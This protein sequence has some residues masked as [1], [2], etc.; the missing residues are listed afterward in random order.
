MRIEI[1]VHELQKLVK[2]AGMGAASRSTKPTLMG[3]KLDAHDDMLTASGTDLDVGVSRTIACQVRRAGAC[4]IPWSKVSQ[5]LGEID[6]FVELSADESGC[7]VKQMGTRNK[8]DFPTTDAA[9]FPDVPSDHAGGSFT[10]R[11]ESLTRALD[12]SE[13]ACGKNDNSPRF[14]I[15]GLLFEADADGVAVV[16]TDL[17]RIGTAAVEA[18]VNGEFPKGVLV[19][20]KAVSLL[21]SVL[22]GQPDDVTVHAGTN[23]ALVKCGGTV[24]Y[25]RLV[26]GKF[27]EWQKI[28]PKKSE[29]SLTLDAAAFEAKVR[30]A[31]ITSDEENKRVDMVFTPGG[32]T[33]RAMGA[34]SGSSDV[35]LELPGSTAEVEIAFDPRYLIGVG[36]ACLQSGSTEMTLEMTNCEKPAVFKWTGGMGL[37]MPMGERS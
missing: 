3:V 27:P 2:L 33:M 31:A 21:R 22:A 25:S 4:V 19:P 12:Q 9:E 15:N 16:G 37:V 8:W 23:D 35:W 26:Q 28:K 34:E 32:V 29:Y 5:L 17:K 14:S 11:G 36:K 6:G 24:V 10:C 7:V 13:Y 30:Q 18:K 1:A 20:L